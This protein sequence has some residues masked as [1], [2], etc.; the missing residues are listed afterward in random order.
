MA[1]ERPLHR[2]LER[3]LADHYGQE[4]CVVLVSGHGTNVTVIGAILG[5]RDLVIHDSLAHNSIVLGAT[6][7][8]AARRS[9]PPQ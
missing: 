7:S 9:F 5:P 2:E 3:A 6:L 4:D 8:G 1:G